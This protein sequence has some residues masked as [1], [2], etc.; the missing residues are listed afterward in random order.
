M[1]NGPEN[2]T[3][4]SW[5]ISMEEVRLAKFNEEQ[6]IQCPSEQSFKDHLLIW[7]KVRKI[8]KPM[9]CQ[10]T[11]E[12]LSKKERTFKLVVDAP[13]KEI[14]M[15]ALI[16]VMKLL[17]SKGIEPAVIVQVKNLKC[18]EAEEILEGMKEVLYA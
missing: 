3:S 18:G 16:E 17:Q 6:I 7:G 9:E 10:F 14:Q 4:F 1:R 8:T 12:V 13:S 2:Q 15:N 5:E 11:W